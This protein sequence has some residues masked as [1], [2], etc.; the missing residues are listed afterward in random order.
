MVYSI[1]CEDMEEELSREE[2]TKALF[3]TCPWKSLGLYDFPVRFYQ[4]SWRK[5]GSMLCDF[6]QNGLKQ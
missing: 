6:V 4:K 2:I 3:A 5:V 1:V